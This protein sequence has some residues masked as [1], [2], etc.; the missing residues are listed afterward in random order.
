MMLTFLM[1]KLYPSPQVSVFVEDSSQ[2]CK[3]MH[4]PSILQKSEVWFTLRDPGGGD[5]VLSVLSGGHLLRSRNIIP[6]SVPTL[7]FEVIEA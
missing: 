2:K 6:V 5:E 3:T 1:G 4:H 7:V